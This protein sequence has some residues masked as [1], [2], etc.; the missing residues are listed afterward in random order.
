MEKILRLKQL[1]Q[2][3]KISRKYIA[4]CLNVSEFFLSERETLFRK[5]S[6]YFLAKYKKVL[7]AEIERKEGKAFVKTQNIFRY[8][9]LLLEQELDEALIAG[10][11]YVFPKIAC[12]E[13]N[14][15]NMPFYTFSFEKKIGRLYQFR[16]IAAG[17]TVTLSAAQLLNRFQNGEKTN[18]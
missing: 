3:S 18:E 12:N 11:I 1:R 9:P 8:S 10:K 16:N 4:K 2:E 13:N 17:Y 7:E 15:K 14:V 5:S 6:A